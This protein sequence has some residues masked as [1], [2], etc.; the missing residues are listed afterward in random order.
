[1]N[2]ELTMEQKQAIQRF[3]LQHGLTSWKKAARR[4]WARAVAFEPYEQVVYA[5]RNTHGPGWLVRV[6]IDESGWLK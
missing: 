1:M 4:L 5:L 2:S 3:V 6:R